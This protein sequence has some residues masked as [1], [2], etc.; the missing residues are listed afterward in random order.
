MSAHP[1]PLGH[2]SLGVR[3]YTVSKAF[4][5]AALTPIGLRLVYDSEAEGP[6]P[7]GN[8]RTLGYGPDENRE[9][10]NIFEFKKA[11][12]P[13]A[14]FHVAFNAPTRES[15]IEFHAKAL[16]FGGKNNGAPGVRNHYGDNYFAAFIICPDGWR[17][18][19]VC[20]TKKEEEAA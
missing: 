9:L 11:S 12:P 14:G 13:G 19:A 18:E 2:M 8:T 4:Y 17:L 10:L 20:K 15:V 6:S 1:Q 16:E 3:N 5:T 7:K